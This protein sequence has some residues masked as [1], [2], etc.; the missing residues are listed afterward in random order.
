MSFGYDDV[1]NSDF[2]ANLPMFRFPKLPFRQPESSVLWKIRS[3]HFSQNDN[4]RAEN[5][6]CNALLSEKSTRLIIHRTNTFFYAMLFCAICGR[7]GRLLRVPDFGRSA[8]SERV[9]NRMTW[10]LRG[11][12]AILLFIFHNRCEPRFHFF[13]VRERWNGERCRKTVMLFLK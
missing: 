4:K 9:V 10:F 6:H 13:T 3:F 12:Y 5:T 8:V 7:S 2:C 11:L 1:H